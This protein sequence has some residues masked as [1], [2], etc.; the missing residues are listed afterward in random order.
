MTHKKRTE[1]PTDRAARTLRE[2]RE[3]LKQNHT[4]SEYR[5]LG[6]QLQKRIG[7]IDNRLRDTQ[8]PTNPGTGGAAYLQALNDGS[9][10][11]LAALDDER[12]VLEAERRQLSALGKQ[13]KQ[14]RDAQQVREAHDQVA[15]LETAAAAA[16]QALATFVA[17]Q[18]TVERRQNRI[19]DAIRLAGRTGETPPEVP[20]ELA[21]RVARLIQR[22]GR[23]QNAAR[24]RV[25]RQL[26][27]EATSTLLR[28]AAEAPGEPVGP[29]TDTKAVNA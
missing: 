28:Q 17:A 22:D 11:D 1:A 10:D 26:G 23:Q 8:P 3:A 9:P 6:Q 2:V 25:F 21:V 18:S 24:I 14:L 15:E 16:E 27:V 4:V 19:G 12:Q 7:E 20:A 13:L 5:G 29:A